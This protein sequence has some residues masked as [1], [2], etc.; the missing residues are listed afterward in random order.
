MFTDAQEGNHDTLRDRGECKLCRTT[1]CKPLLFCLLGDMS[2][3]ASEGRGYIIVNII[4]TVYTD[5]PIK[6]ERITRH[7]AQNS[8]IG[9]R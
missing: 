3:V 6:L 4:V 5:H 8:F 7:K 9:P 2:Y 1:G